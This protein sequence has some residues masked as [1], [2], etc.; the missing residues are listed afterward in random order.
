MRCTESNTEIKPNLQKLHFLNEWSY[1]YLGLLLDS[2][3][4]FNKHI[5]CICKKAN[6]TLAF[7][8]RNTYFCQQK[9][10]PHLC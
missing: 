6:S 7:N 8:I 3:L 1:K 2:K 4:T 10:I 5:N 9:I